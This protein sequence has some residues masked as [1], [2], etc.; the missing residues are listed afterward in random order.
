ML[1]PQLDDLVALRHQ[2]YQLGLISSQR[3]QTPLS[4]LYASVF[5]GQGVDFDEV[6]EYQ[7]GDETRNIDWRVTAR[8]GKPYLKVYREERERNVVLCVDISA[9]MQFG[10]RHTFK[11]VQAAY[12]AALLG[13]SAQGH[14]DRVGGLLFG[15]DK[16]QFFRPSRSP[17]TFWQ[18]LNHLT[19]AST[20]VS[21]HK[22]TLEQALTLLNRSSATGALLFVIADFHQIPVL[23]LQ[24]VLSQL[25][26]R[27]EVVLINIEDPADY[28]LPAMGWV[29]FVAPGGHQIQVNTDNPRG[30]A[31]YRHIWETQQQQLQQLARRLY[32]D[33]FSLTTQSDVYQSLLTYLRQ[34][35]R[36]QR[37]HR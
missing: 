13:W 15:Q 32:V 17:S 16:P 36:Q 1:A 3:M 10:T 23:A 37:T 29:H 21:T 4:G 28:D 12:T 5:R 2:A 33:F 24:R 27:H 11:S 6:R 18:L 35:A 7:P 26:Q 30:R 8:T 22:T 9:H 14:G 34:R 19:V 25:R 31:H 20:T